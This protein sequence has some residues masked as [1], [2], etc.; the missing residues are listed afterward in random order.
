MS[1]PYRFVRSARL[2][3]LLTLGSR[4]LGVVREMTYSQ[5]FGASPILSAYRVAF[6]VPNL[7]R[8]LFGEGALTSSFIPVF[9]RSR[10]EEGDQ[11]ARRLAGGV[12]TL[13][14]VLLVVLLILTECLL[15]AVRVHTWNPTLALT[16]ILMPYMVLICLTAVLGGMLNALD[17]FTAPALA[18][19]ILNIVVIVAAWYGGRVLRLKPQ[20]HLVLICCAV[21]VAG[22]LQMA[23]QVV[24]LWRIGFI[25]RWNLNWSHPA[26]RQVLRLMTPMVLGMS[27]VQV[28]TLADS[29]IA[30]L[31]VP[32]GRGPAI[33]GYAQYLYHLPLGVF[34]TALATAI[35]PLLA[36]HAAAD[37]AAGFSAAVERGLRTTLFISIPAGVG[38][39]LIATPAVR[40]LFEHGEFTPADSVRVV[41]ALWCYCTAIWAYSVQHILIRAFY[42]LQD[43]RAPFRIALAMVCLNV[44]L[45]LILVG[46]FQEAGVAAATA[47][48]ACVQIV[49]LGYGLR[50]RMG[51]LPLGGVWPTLWR[52]VVATALMGLAVWAVRWAWAWPVGPISDTVELTA[53]ITVG[54][55]VFLLCAR[56]AGL[57]EVAA[58]LGIKSG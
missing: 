37:D 6:Q 33:L 25:P 38:M 18:P 19:T 3:A 32:D 27:A 39:M 23:S 17:R 41:G 30:L 55:L 42:S 43:S 34:G 40:L 45:N 5:F 15:L 36:R 57:E 31:M 29:I 54:A 56:V 10:L 51:V 49:M 52:T 28:N 7:A 9:S 24:W 22:V 1:D 20:P 2:I 16:A 11:A 50:V 14:A 26:V 35:F 48:S 4:V 58:F 46:P 12:V 47:I 53:M 8:R 13:V 21:L 44:V